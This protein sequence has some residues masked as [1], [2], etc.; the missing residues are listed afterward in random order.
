[1]G[2]P[3]W[4]WEV[5]M[6]RTPQLLFLKSMVEGS[7]KWVSTGLKEICFNRVPMI[8]LAFYRIWS[9][10]PWSEVEGRLSILVSLGSTYWSMNT[11]CSLHQPILTGKVLYVCVCAS[12]TQK[13]FRFSGKLYPVRLLTHLLAYCADDLRGAGFLSQIPCTTYCSVLPS[14]ILP[15]ACEKSGMETLPSLAKCW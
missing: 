12:V 9:V 2:F 5:G 3:A 14:N 8:G 7:R 1:M 15:V 13:I 11:G 6:G 10:P 4:G